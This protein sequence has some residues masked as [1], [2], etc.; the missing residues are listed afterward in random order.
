M[1]RKLK[2]SKGSFV[3]WI[4]GQLLVIAILGWWENA[5]LVLTIGVVTAVIWALFAG[6]FLK[7]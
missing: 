7:V 2:F 6:T 3:G 4:A 1:K 5:P